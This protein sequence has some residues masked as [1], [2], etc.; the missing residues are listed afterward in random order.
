VETNRCSRGSTPP[1]AAGPFHCSSKSM[2]ASGRR[3]PDSTTSRS[4]ELSP[5]PVS[6]WSRSTSVSHRW[7]RTRLHF[8][9]SDEASAGSR[10]TPRS[11]TVTRVASGRWGPRPVATRCC[12]WRSNPI[13]MQTKVRASPIVLESN[14]TLPCCAGR[15]SIRGLGTSGH[16]GREGRT[17]LR[18]MT[19]TGVVP[20]R[21]GKR[22][23]S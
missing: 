17:S 23:R 20:G 8:R 22:T 7:L 16:A 4:F 13:A 15:S 11:S 6:S 2:G 10:G 19:S 18:H 3:A 1:A 21:C 14:S 5:R 12:C 9:T